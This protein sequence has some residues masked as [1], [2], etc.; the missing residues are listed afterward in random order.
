MATPSKR[1]ILVVDDDPSLRETFAMLLVSAGYDVQ[2]AGD[3]FSALLELRKM[4]PDAIISD[5]N[6]PRMSGFEFLSIVRR[7]FPEILTV[8]MSG[9][10]GGEESPPGVVADAVLS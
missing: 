9:A 4:L 1:Q 7:R 5:L 8:A 10:H 2:V 6:M 3:G